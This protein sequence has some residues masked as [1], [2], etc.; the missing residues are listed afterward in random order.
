MTQS[1]E[2]SVQ[3]G[4]ATELG[5]DPTGG[6]WVTRCVKHDAVRH[7]KSRDAA[8]TLSK[9]T[10]EFCETCR[11]AG[12]QE[13]E[14]MDLADLNE[15]D[16]KHP[17]WDEPE[18][19]VVVTDTV[20]EPDNAA[21]ERL[22][23]LSAS[24]ADME[25]DDSDVDEVVQRLFNEAMELEDVSQEVPEMNEPVVLGTFWGNGSGLGH[26]AVTMSGLYMKT[27]CGATMLRGEPVEPTD[28][29]M[30]AVCLGEAET[31][32]VAPQTRKARVVHAKP[33]KAKV[34]HTGPPVSPP[35]PP[36][37]EPVHDP[38]FEPGAV[39]QLAKCATCG[40]GIDPYAWKSFRDGKVFH[41][42][43]PS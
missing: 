24:L 4:K 20:V 38:T 7:V 40:H 33:S 19:T 26:H 6:P 1:T 12:S 13:T 31:V 29:R 2:P 34:T 14:P 35:E 18:V 3:Y 15:M 8:R 37:R 32:T 39:V 30:C 10:S 43:C 17:G 22:R 21:I 5:F 28:E 36:V 41:R 9:N 42:V 27:K 11:D 23:E 16:A 25:P